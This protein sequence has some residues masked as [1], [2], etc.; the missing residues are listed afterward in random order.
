MLEGIALVKHVRVNRVPVATI[1][2]TSRENMGVNICCPK[3]HFSKERGVQIALG[4]AY[5]DTPLVCP[6]RRVVGMSMIQLIQQELS[7]MRL[8]ADLYFK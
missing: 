1:V 6:N 2:A 7:N 4:R 5:Q 3:D 8:R